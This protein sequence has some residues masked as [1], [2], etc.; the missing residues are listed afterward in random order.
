MKQRGETDQRPLETSALRESDSPR[1]RSQTLLLHD[2]IGRR[3]PAKRELQ[4]PPMALSLDTTR[5]LLGLSVCFWGR[6]PPVLSFLPGS[7]F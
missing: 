6:F 7:H 1:C 2:D 4:L 3:Y 5:D